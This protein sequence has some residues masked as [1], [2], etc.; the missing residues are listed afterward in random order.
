MLLESLSRLI[1]S[2]DLP[3]TNWPRTFP[4]PS[5][6]RPLFTSDLGLKYPSSLSSLSKLE[7]TGG[8]ILSKIDLS[9]EGVEGRPAV[10]N[11]LD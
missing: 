7:L 8:G 1:L 6:L 2:V 4:S 3:L 11:E 9:G 5:S 10:L